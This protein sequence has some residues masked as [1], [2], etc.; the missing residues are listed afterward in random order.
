M[1]DLDGLDEFDLQID[2]IGRSLGNAR[3]QAQGVES[4]VLGVRRQLSL[5]DIELR[6]LN[7]GISAGLKR[8]FEDLI[9][10]GERLSDVMRSLGDSISRSVYRSAVSPVFNQL[11]GLLS[12]GIENFVGGLLPFADGAPF[13]QGRVVPFATGGIVNGPVR[14]PMRGGTGLMGEAGPEAILPLSRTADGRLG[15]EAKG[16]GRAVNVVVN[17]STPD[18]AGFERSR[19]QIAAQMSRALARGQRNR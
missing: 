17:V 10:D 9:F 4:D 6:G 11:G 7:R 19:A 5:T 3:E 13:S 16:G 8:S 14:F 18:V 2:A 1:D 12:N 15:V